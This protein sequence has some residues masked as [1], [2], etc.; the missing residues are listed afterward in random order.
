MDQSK[1]IAA[2]LVSTVDTDHV[3]SKNQDNEGIPDDQ[4]SL[5]LLNLYKVNTSTNAQNAQEE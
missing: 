5:I 2:Q 4:K 1:G 3:K